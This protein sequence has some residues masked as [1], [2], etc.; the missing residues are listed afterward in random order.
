MPVII[1]FF[2]CFLTAFLLG[3]IITPRILLISYRKRLF[4][5]PNE[6]KVHAQP[7]PRLGGLSFLPSI[8]IAFC[9]IMAIHDLISTAESGFT[10][11]DTEFLLLAVG[12]MILFLTG[13]GDDLIGLSYISK[14][15]IQLVSALL[16]VLS[17]NWLHSLGGLFG[18]TSLSAWTGI[19]MTVFIIIYIINAINLIDGID[20][21]A[22]GLSCISL[23]ALC[24]LLV[25]IG[26]YA[27]ALLGIATLGVLIPFW[28]YNV[29]GTVQRGHKLFMGDVGSLTLGFI[30][31]FLV[32]HIGNCANFE[33]QGKSLVL[34]FSTL[35]VP[36]F[37]VVRVVIHRLREHRNPFLPDN[38]H[39]HHKLLRTGLHVRQVMAV[40]L[41]VSVF[42]LLMNYCLC[43]VTGITTILF[44][45]S[46]LWILIHLMIDYAMAIRKKK[47][48][49]T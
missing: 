19:L 49:V 18:I 30:L 23:S 5:I 35:L 37:D 20:G 14:I 48:H 26:H 43:S 41:L 42:F 33:G 29:F 22:S 34:A 11:D 9:L 7:V 10:V 44:I 16:L 47:E 8:L 36:L 38:N 1:Y 32:I 31:A 3:W 25:G 2:G 28:F 21:L 24:I 46:I 15:C 45:D 6:R 27:Y 12:C 4:D 40:I 13:V 39:F 17:G